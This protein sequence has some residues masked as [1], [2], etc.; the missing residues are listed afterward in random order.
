M[1]SLK[2]RPITIVNI[3]QYLIYTAILFWFCTPWLTQYHHILPIWVN[4]IH[5]AIIV[6]LIFTVFNLLQGAIRLS[7]I[8]V[9]IVLFFISNIVSIIVNHISPLRGLIGIKEYLIPILFFYIIRYDN[10]NI[11]KSK[12]IINLFLIIGVFELVL[13]FFQFRLGVSRDMIVGTFGKHQTGIL[14]VFV[15]GLFSITISMYY[16]LKRKRYIYLSMLYCFIPILNSAKFFTILVFIPISV[17]CA[18]MLIEF[19]I[20][21][22][23]IVTT[24]ILI[25]VITFESL[26]YQFYNNSILNHFTVR[27]FEHLH[28]QSDVNSERSGRIAAILYTAST[29]DSPVTALLGH[30]PGTLRGSLLGTKSKTAVTSKGNPFYGAA[31]GYYITLFQSGILGVG[32]YLCMLYNLWRMGRRTFKKSKNSFIIALSMA[33]ISIIILFVLGELYTMLWFTNFSSFV[34]ILAGI[35]YHFDKSQQRMAANEMIEAV[36]TL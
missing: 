15:A 14:A 10:Y 25:T 27:L 26:H 1:I 34:W 29:F 12:N 30:G 19:K 33:F 31:G 20:K 18:N 17:V 13:V 2:N 22:F 7:Y 6:M 28:N 32:L 4:W 23:L 24:T 36:K 9:S 5:Q 16:I 21:Q 8:D 35:L 3:P 11:E